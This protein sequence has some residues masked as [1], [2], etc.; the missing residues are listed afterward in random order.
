MTEKLPR[1][2]A[3]LEA[4]AVRLQLK[5]GIRR[6]GTAD[7]EPCFGYASAEEVSLALV[8][9]CDRT[10]AVGEDD[11]DAQRND[12]LRR[13]GFLR[14]TGGNAAGNLHGEGAARLA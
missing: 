5:V 10:S 4:D 9:Q 1:R 12:G 11:A 8:V 3:R 14:I 6:K 7:G 13:G 2:R